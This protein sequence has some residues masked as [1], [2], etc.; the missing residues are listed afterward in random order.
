MQGGPNM[1]DCPMYDEAEAEL[2]RIERIVLGEVDDDDW[3]D[4]DAA[5]DA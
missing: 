5:A 3:H 1:H 4:V 2:D